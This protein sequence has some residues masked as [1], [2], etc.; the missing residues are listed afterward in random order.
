MG[1]FVYKIWDLDRE[2]Y[3]SYRG[4]KSLWV[5]SGDAKAA[6]KRQLYHTRKYGLNP[7]SYDEQSRFVIHTFL[8]KQVEL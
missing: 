7:P 4:R 2:E 5:R 3:M 1:T 8:L 6:V